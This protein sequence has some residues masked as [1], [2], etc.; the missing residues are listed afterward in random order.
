MVMLDRIRDSLE[1]RPGMTLLD[2][3]CGPGS[4]S[5]FFSGIPGVNIISLDQDEGSVTRVRERVAEEGI[6]NIDVRQGSILEIP[7]DDDSVDV[8]FM[9][10]VF[11]GLVA[12]GELAG[13]MEVF[14]V[15]SP[16]GLF[17]IV[18]FDKADTGHG[19]PIEV[20]VSPEQ[21]R[22]ILGRY[23]FTEV[24]E[25]RAGPMHYLQLFSTRA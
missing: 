21:L 20:R 13:I 2:A 7:L 8:V 9:A 11:H 3:G 6:T 23:G 18:E 14:R 17:A 15:L 22:E 16:D 1:L 19:P 25:D 4:Y 5:V 10:N 12:N 24:S